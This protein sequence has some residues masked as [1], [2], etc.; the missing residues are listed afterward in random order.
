M[1]KQDYINFHAETCKKMLELTKKKNADY[2]GDSENPFLN[3]TSCEANQIGTTEQGFLM[4]M[5]DKMQRIISF[6]NTGELLVKD[7]S[8]EDTLFDLAN[9]CILFLGYLESKKGNQYVPVDKEEAYYYPTAVTIPS[10]SDIT[11][12]GSFGAE[13]DPYPSP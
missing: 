13:Y 12:Y 8:V 6:N 5:N 2:T 1:N 11:G 10:V 7:E 3:F 9:Y 4:R